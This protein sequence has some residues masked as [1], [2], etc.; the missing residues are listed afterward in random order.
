MK[1]TI[2]KIVI[3]HFDESEINENNQQLEAPAIVTTVWDDDCVNLKVLNDGPENTWKTS[4]VQGTE[5]NQWS[6]P[7]LVTEDSDISENTKKDPA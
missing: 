6:W 4:V 1:P 2:G 7:E 5:A 3:F